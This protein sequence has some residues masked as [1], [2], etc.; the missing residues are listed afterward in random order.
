MQEIYF[1]TLWF[2]YF[3]LNKIYTFLLPGAIKV[4]WYVNYVY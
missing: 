4:I 3:N 1:L 2:F